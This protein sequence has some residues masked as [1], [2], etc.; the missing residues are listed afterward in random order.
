VHTV[1]YTTVHEMFEFPATMSP[2]VSYSTTVLTSAYRPDLEL[3]RK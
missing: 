3:I 1:P 2:A